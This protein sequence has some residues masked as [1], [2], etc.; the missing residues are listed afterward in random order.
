[1]TFADLPVGAIVFLDANPLIYHFAPH[2][3][4]AA[5]CS[6]L[7]T[8]IRKQE[9]QA[10]TSTHVLSEVAHHLMT[11]EA[12][13]L[14]GWTS[15]I[16]SHLKKQP[17]QIQKLTNFRKSID[18]VPQLGIQL[19]TILPTWISLAAGLSQ[20]YGLF[21]NDALIVAIMHANGWTSLAS[22]DPDFDRVPGLKRYA[23]L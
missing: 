8:R 22:N 5:P 19:V 12:A 18:S 10:F 3:I 6:Q 13:N 15:K 11:L 4:L 23:P 2:P 20:Q 1:M 14:F 21:S 16:V 17:T 7:L 9:I